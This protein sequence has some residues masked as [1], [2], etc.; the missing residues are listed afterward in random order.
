MPANRLTTLLNATVTERAKIASGVNSLVSL[1]ALPCDLLDC[2]AGKF[3]QN[4][5]LDE[6]ETMRGTLKIL[7]SRIEPAAK[8]G[9]QNV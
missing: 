8:Q 1:D 6:L 2:I 7:L 4:A 3:I 5:S 9:A